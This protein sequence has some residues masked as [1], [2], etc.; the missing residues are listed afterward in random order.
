MLR[1]EISYYHV[2]NFGFYSNTRPLKGPFFGGYDD[3]KLKFSSWLKMQENLGSTSPVTIAEGKKGVFCK[4]FYVDTETGEF[5][6]VLWNELSNKEGNI[7]SVSRDQR[8]GGGE[9]KGAGDVNSI[10]GLP[11]YFWFVPK[12]DLVISIRFDHSSDNVRCVRDYISAFFKNCTSYRHEDQDGMTFYVKEYDSEMHCRFKFDW[13]KITRKLEVNKLINKADKITGIVRQVR[14]VKR[15]TDERNSSR[16]LYDKCSELLENVLPEWL[17]DGSDTSNNFIEELRKSESTDL[18]ITMPYK[19]NETEFGKLIH[20]YFNSI[21][22]TVPE[23]KDKIGFK[24]KGDSKIEWLDDTDIVK[25]VELNLIFSQE[26]IPKA[27]EVLEALH[28]QS[29][30]IMSEIGTN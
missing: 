17:R 12:D 14:L 5:L 7:L 11:S 28:E 9:V 15:V 8:I 20:K 30:S 21:E 18:K 3:F 16:R 27:V 22:D 1:A 10:I 2:L 29:H 26:K 25:K 13:E 24:F 4:D 19:S 23:M 6:I